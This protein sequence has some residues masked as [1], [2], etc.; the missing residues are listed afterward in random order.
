MTVNRKK[1]ISKKIHKKYLSDVRCFIGSSEKW[2]DMLFKA[3]CGEVFRVNR[4][5]S[6]RLQSVIERYELNYCVLKESED[7][8]RGAIVVFFPADFVTV[9]RRALF[10]A[11]GGELA[12][13]IV[14]AHKM[15]QERNA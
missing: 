12:S 8:K 5:D 14:N 7:S 3:K 6:A 10:L 2:R 11:P 15:R 9:K 1:R 13:E 4:V